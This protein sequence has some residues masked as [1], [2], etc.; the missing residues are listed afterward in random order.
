MQCVLFVCLSVSYGAQEK[1]SPNVT[2]IIATQ[3]HRQLKIPPDLPDPCQNNPEIFYSES[4]VANCEFV[5]SS[6]GNI[7]TTDFVA[8]LEENYNPSDD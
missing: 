5:L 2:I 6:S 1:Y 7:S 3:A 4:L 8:V